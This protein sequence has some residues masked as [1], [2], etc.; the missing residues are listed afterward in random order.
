MK[1]THKLLNASRKNKS[2][3]CI[4]LDPDPELMPEVDVL[5]FNKAIIEATCDLVCAYKPNL[6]F[7]EVLGTEGLAILEKTIKH[8]PSDI[9]AIGDA[10]RGDIGNTARAYARALFSVLDFDAATVNPYLGFDSIEPFISYHDKGVF[11]LCRTSNK[12]A[13]DFQD[14]RTNGLPL[15]EAVARKAQE[16]NIHG[17]IGLVVGATYPDELR[18]VRS[19][20]PEMP[21]LIPGIGAQGGDLASAVGHGVDARGE[22]AIINVSRQILYASKEKDFAQA[23]RKVAEKIRKQIND[24][25]NKAR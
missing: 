5:Q 20:C 17:N 2:W 16:W 21:L 9:P 13:T 1:F 11:I 15:Y 18:R 14:L 23:A 8:I 3:L 12:G 10:K 19:I 22:K 6:A 25:R 24:Y 7:Y 4:G